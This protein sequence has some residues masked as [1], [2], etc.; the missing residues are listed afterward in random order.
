MYVHAQVIGATVGP[1]AAIAEVIARLTDVA[2]PAANGRRGGIGVPDRPAKHLC[3]RAT[4]TEVGDVVVVVVFYRL[5]VRAA[6]QAVGLTGPVD[7]ITENGPPLLAWL[8]TLG[9]RRAPLTA[10]GAND[11]FGHALDA[12]VLG[13]GRLIVENAESTSATIEVAPALGA[14]GSARAVTVEEELVDA[15]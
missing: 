6:R 2:A 7:G 13:N 9:R 5:V 12:G 14:V 4:I 15:R 3:P 10:S 1:V 8:A 11:G